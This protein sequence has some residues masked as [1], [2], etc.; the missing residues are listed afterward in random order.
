MTVA[1]K[2]DLENRQ[3]SKE[4]GMNFARENKMLFIEA[5]AKTRVGVE[6]C[7]GELFSFSCFVVFEL[8]C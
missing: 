3:V 6:K 4:E 5:S 1:N 8:F 7:F 2:V